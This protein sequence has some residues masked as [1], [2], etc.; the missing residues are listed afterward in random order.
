M[1]L[2]VLDTTMQRQLAY[3]GKLLRQARQARKWSQCTVAASLGISRAMVSTIERGL[4]G[5]NE[6]KMHVF[7]QYAT[8]LGLSLPMLF[9]EHPGSVLGQLMV[10]LTAC[11]DDTLLV[12]LELVHKIYPPSNGSLPH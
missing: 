9:P 4:W 1:S 8:L 11:P 3:A 5:Q 10:A 6:A 2:S 12:V 7:L